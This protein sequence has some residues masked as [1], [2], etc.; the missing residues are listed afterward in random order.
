[1]IEEIRKLIAGGNSFLLSTNDRNGFPNTIVVSKPIARVDFHTLKFYVDGDGDTVKNIQQ[2]NKGN[3]CCYND[4]T[5]ESLLLKGVFS[6]HSIEDYQ[7]IE[8]R[9]NDYQKLL[10]HKNPV[11]LSFEV[12]TAKIH[13][14]GTTVF[15]E[16]D[17]P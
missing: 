2:N 8:D 15:K 17:K 4:G 7:V 13:Q 16:I 5:F 11:I 9:L 12:Y 3:V 14:Y 6:V 1:M 10:N